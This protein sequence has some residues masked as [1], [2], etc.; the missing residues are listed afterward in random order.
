MELTATPEAI[1]AAAMGSIG[2]LVEQVPIVET[3]AHLVG[4]T[5]NPYEAQKL[6][7]DALRRVEPQILRETGVIDT[8]KEKKKHR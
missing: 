4:A 5:N 1:Y 2:A 8:Q 6:K 7:E 3:G